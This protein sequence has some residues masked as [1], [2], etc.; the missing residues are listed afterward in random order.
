MAGENDA[1]IEDIPAGNY[2]V[3]VTD[4]NDCTETAAA[5]VAAYPPIVFSA[6]ADSAT[7]FGLPDGA[8]TLQSPDTT[9]VFS[10]DGGVFSQNKIYENLTGGASFTR[11]WPKTCMAARIPCRSPCCRRRNSYSSCPLMPRSNWAI[12]WK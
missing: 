7:C 12:R 3:T 5:T 1:A 2:E 11:C 9:L 6:E 4:A 10:L 8:I